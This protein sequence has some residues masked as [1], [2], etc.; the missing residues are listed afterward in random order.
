MSLEIRTLKDHDSDVITIEFKISLFVNDIDS[1]CQ[2]V[3]EIT[4]SYNNID[5]IL[6]HR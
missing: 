2:I 3:Q 6:K 1:Y 4:K 5:N